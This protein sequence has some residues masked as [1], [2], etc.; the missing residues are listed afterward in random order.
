M[1]YHG[2][3]IEGQLDIFFNNQIFQMLVLLI[4]CYLF[5]YLFIYAYLSFQFILS[6][7]YFPKGQLLKNGQ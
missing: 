3:E 2:K 5:R 7:V 6:F 1:Y 4:K